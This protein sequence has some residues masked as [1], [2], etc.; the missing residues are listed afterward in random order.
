ML[1]AL[2]IS[3]SVTSCVSIHKYDDKWI[4]CNEIKVVKLDNPDSLSTR[5]IIEIYSNNLIIQDKCK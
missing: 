1:M 4:S 5:D 3:I 2:M